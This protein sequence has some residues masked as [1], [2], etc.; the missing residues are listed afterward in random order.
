MP[1]M[2]DGSQTRGK[3]GGVSMDSCSRPSLPGHA[4]PGSSWNASWWKR[5][6]RLGAGVESWSISL[7]TGWRAVQIQAGPSAVVGLRYPDAVVQD[8]DTTATQESAVRARLGGAD[9][10]AGCPPSSNQPQTQTRGLT[11]PLT[12]AQPFPSF[13]TP[14]PSSAVFGY[15]D[16]S[17]TDSSHSDTQLPVKHNQLAG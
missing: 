1:A 12:P 7:A 3:A 11:N 14:S 8:A 9:L 13:V 5:F 4:R 2:T 6:W 16:E 15:S 17:K 10:A